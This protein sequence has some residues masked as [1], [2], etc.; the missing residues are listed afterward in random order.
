MAHNTTHYLML[1]RSVSSNHLS[2]LH[3]LFNSNRLSW[4][5]IDCLEVWSHVPFF[6]WS[7]L[8]VGFFTALWI[9]LYCWQHI[10]CVSND[11]S[12]HIFS[13]VQHNL[14]TW[15]TQWACL[16][17]KYNKAYKFT[18]LSLL[19]D[20]HTFLAVMRANLCTFLSTLNCSIWSRCVN[21]EI[22]S[23]FDVA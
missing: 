2:W 10:L 15:V 12:L 22:I 4:W 9:G 11:N 13:L 6:A 16:E 20:Q 21:L 3:W 17:L 18:R 5:F 8:I 19:C 14:M 23:A 7:S 1:F